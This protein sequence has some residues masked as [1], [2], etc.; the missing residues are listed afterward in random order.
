MNPG[1]LSPLNFDRYI[2]KFGFCRL[3]LTFSFKYIDK[4]YLYT[5]MTTAPYPYDLPA[6]AF[7]SLLDF[8]P[9]SLF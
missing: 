9:S 6:A 2:L 8:F 1:S 5:F 7:F 4:E 3:D